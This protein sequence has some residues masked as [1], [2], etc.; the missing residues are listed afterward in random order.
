MHL[1]FSPAGAC[2]RSSLCFKPL[3]TF[4][5]PSV[6]PLRYD[7]MLHLRQSQSICKPNPPSGD[8]RS[9]CSRDSPAFLMFRGRLLRPKT[10]SLSL[11]VRMDLCDYVCVCVCVCVC[12][13]ER[14][15]ATRRRIWREEGNRMQ[16]ALTPILDT[17]E[18]A[19][20][21]YYPCPCI[22]CATRSLLTFSNRHFMLPPVLQYSL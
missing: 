5:G 22:P 2:V 16:T 12:V 14:K 8:L 18:W 10:N 19:M 3:V 6:T 17:A 1:R 7:E 21:E 11:S 20:A 9:T 15:R 4:P 13:Y